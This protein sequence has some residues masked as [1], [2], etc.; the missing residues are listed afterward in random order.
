MEPPV[1]A[2]VQT[3]RWQTLLLH[4]K[5][6]STGIK[7]HLIEERGLFSVKVAIRA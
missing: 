2:A 5:E 6:E 1:G 4:A 3:L 7:K